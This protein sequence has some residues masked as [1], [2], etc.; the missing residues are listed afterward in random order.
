MIKTLIINLSLIFIFIFIFSSP[1]YAQKQTAYNLPSNDKIA[2][3]TQVIG[4]SGPR[5]FHGIDGL[6][7]VSLK[8]GLEYICVSFSFPNRSISESTPRT[9]SPKGSLYIKL[10]NDSIIELKSFHQTK[11]TYTNPFFEKV[12]SFTNWFKLSKDELKWWKSFFKSK[13]S[14]RCILKVRYFIRNGDPEEAESYANGSPAKNFQKYI[15]EV[16]KYRRK[17]DIKKNSRQNPTYG[18]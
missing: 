13:D 17:E 4:L 8:S 18:M 9:M 11:Q 10:S 1:S 16:D 6:Y 12:S 14:H 3:R 15:D 2:V 5:T 7:L